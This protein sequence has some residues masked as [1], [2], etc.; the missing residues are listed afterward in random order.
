MEFCDCVCMSVDL[1]IT[2]ELMYECHV[3][4][5]QVRSPKIQIILETV[6]FQFH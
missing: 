2:L 4:L 5:L 6:K 3:H 1:H